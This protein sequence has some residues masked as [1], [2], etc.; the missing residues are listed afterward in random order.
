MRLGNPLKK[1]SQATGVSFD[2]IGKNIESSTKDSLKKT[3]LAVGKTLQAAGKV[4]SLGTW[5]GKIGETSSGGGFQDLVNAG[6]AARSAEEIQASE[7]AKGLQDAADE[8]RRR[9]MGGRASTVLFGA[10]GSSLFGGGSISRRT[11]LGS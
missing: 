9:S 8:Q 5:N 10:G 11:L 4:A 6:A 1:L 3:E 7:D 2:S